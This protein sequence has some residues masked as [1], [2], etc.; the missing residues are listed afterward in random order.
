MRCWFAALLGLALWV[1]AAYALEPSSELALELQTQRRQAAER[2]IAQATVQIES[3]SLDDKQV[4]AAFRARAAARNRLLQHAEAVMDLSRAVELDPFNPLYYEERAITHLKL[5]EF[6]QADLDLEMALGLDST[7]LAAQREKGR[8]AFYRG[9]YQEAAHAMTRLA[10]DAEGQTFVYSVLWLEL[11]IRRG[12]LERQS[13]LAL[14]EQELRSEQW[15]APLVQMYQGRLSPAEAI[16]AA[17]AP[18][19]RVALEQQCEAYFYAG[20]EYL[21]RQEPQQ[22]RAAFEAAIATGMTDF[23]EYDWAVRELELLADGGSW[24][25]SC[26]FVAVIGWGSRQRG[27][28]I[29]ASTTSRVRCGANVSTKS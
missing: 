22:A 13:R 2:A 28:P 8:L 6:R 12:H 5:R 9:D 29:A 18:D 24:C 25:Y 17:A 3:A 27:W 7:R 1:Q 16:A 14:A 15:P 10:R 21:L 4:A 19:A 11:A 20:Q 26:P 23:L